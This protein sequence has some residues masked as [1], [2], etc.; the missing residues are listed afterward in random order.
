MSDTDQPREIAV[1]QEPMPLPPQ[2]SSTDTSNQDNKVSLDPSGEKY[3]RT[4]DQ[5]DLV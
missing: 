3:I 2:T 4:I 5:T 1:I